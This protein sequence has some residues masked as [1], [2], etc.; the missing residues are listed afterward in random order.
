MAFVYAEIDVVDLKTDCSFEGVDT[1]KKSISFIVFVL[2]LSLACTC[3]F[4]ACDKKDSA[5][6]KFETADE[7]YYVNY[8]SSVLYQPITDKNV[9]EQL[10]NMLNDCKAI[11]LSEEESA[12]AREQY[13]FF[14]QFKIGESEFVLNRAGY[15][16]PNIPYGTAGL[17]EIASSQIYKFE[18]FD[19]EVYR[20]ILKAAERTK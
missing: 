16:L 3:V 11:L 4:C 15:Y 18:G 1:M 20:S 19:D 13:S 8:S 5:S 9:I 6:I 14:D 12:Q 17:S 10:V 7:V 2:M